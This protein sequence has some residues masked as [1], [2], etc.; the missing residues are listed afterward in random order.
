MKNNPAFR[1]YGKAPLNF[2]NSIMSN[3]HANGFEDPGAVKVKREE[4]KMVTETLEQLEEMLKK[5]GSFYKLPKKLVDDPV[6][7]EMSCDAKFLYMILLDRKDLSLSNGNDWRDDRGCVFIYFTIEEMM[8]ITHYGNKKINELLKELEK[9]HLILRRHRGL[10]KPNRIYVN[11]VMVEDL[12]WSP[13]KAK[14]GSVT[15][16]GK[17]D[18]RGWTYAEN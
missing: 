4:E 13:V 15:V 18:G 5:P 14:T 1:I 8:R 10:G 6:Y 3:E 17:D 9:N 12:N 11:N 2:I 16:Y 7:S